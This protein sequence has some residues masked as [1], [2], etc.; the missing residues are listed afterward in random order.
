MDDPGRM[1]P[2][3]EPQAFTKVGGIARLRLFSPHGRKLDAGAGG[4]VGAGGRQRKAV[5]AS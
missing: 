1:Q 5:S 2:A 4:A 3:Q